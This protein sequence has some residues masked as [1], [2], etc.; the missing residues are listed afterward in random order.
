MT[1]LRSLLYLQDARSTARLDAEGELVRL[2]DQDRSLWDRQEIHAGMSLLGVALRHPS[3]LP[4][5]YVAQAAI[6]ACHDI[7]PTWKATNWA[8]IVSWYDTLVVVAD[9]PVVRL[10]RAVAI[11]ELEGPLAGLAELKRIAHLTSYLPFVT[12]RAELLARAR[13]DAEAR[14]EFRAAIQLP[15]NDATKRELAR[16]LAESGSSSPRTR[17]DADARHVDTP[18]GI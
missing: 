5:P 2:P 4:H 11:G 15:G 18:D 7:A 14:A 17:V 10:N 1:G 9:T 3:E 6:A 8:A 12:A 16:R 13:R